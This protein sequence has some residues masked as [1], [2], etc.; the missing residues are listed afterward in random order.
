MEK[1][2][3]QTTCNCRQCQADRYHLAKFMIVCKTCGNKR[4]PKATDHRFQCSGLNDPGQNGS[5]FGGYQVK[6]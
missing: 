5:V 4:C 6:P 3:D 2:E 1:T